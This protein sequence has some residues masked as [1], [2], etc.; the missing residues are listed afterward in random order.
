MNN[1]CATRLSR[2]SHFNS[3]ARA[4]K[5]VSEKSTQV[6]LKNLEELYHEAEYWHV[7]TGGETNISTGADGDTVT[8]EDTSIVLADQYQMLQ[9]LSGQKVEAATEI[10]LIEMLEKRPWLNST[11][12]SRCSILLKNKS[13]TDAQRAK[14]MV[15]HAK[16]LLA[17]G[18]SAS[19][20]P[21]I[22]KVQG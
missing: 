20:L 6:D 22:E 17:G 8:H 18:N 11:V 21:I 3:D 9:A 16:A 14:V 1:A 2:Y 5:R 7:N 4:I 13:L 10:R 12:L 19:C 15:L